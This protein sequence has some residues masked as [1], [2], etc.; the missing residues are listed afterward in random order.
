MAI[1]TYLSTIEP[2]KQTKENKKNR[3]RLMD[4]ESSLMVAR[5]VRGLGEWVKR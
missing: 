3:D 4:T 5:W 2:E 1:S